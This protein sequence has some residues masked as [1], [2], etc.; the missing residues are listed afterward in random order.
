MRA[1]NRAVLKGGENPNAPLTWRCGSRKRDDLLVRMTIRI[2]P[3][4]RGGKTVTANKHRDEA[5]R[6]SVLVDDRFDREFGS[7][8]EPA[9]LTLDEGNRR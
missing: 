5:C 6:G 4:G 7:K 3:D 1:L 9:D 8:L 2:A